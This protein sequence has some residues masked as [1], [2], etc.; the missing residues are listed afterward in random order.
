MFYNSFNSHL[1][2]IVIVIVLL[3]CC[4]L[5][6]T[7]LY[8]RRNFPLSIIY[9]LNNDRPTDIYSFHRTINY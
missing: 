5:Y 7:V 9:A 3:Y 2:L 6:C 1:W 8:D 4:V